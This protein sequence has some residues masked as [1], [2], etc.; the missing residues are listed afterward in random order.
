MVQVTSEDG[1]EFVN[2][3]SEKNRDGAALNWAA[4]ATWIKEPESFT[5]IAAATHEKGKT[6]SKSQ[7]YVIRHLTEH[8]A[9]PLPEI[10]AGADIC[11]PGTARN[12]VYSLF[13]WGW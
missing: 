6:L 7:E 8:G 2:F 3:K 1:S 5:M 9:S 4:K 13:H 12:A 10:M 11:S